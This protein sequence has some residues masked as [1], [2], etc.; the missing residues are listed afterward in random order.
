MMVPHVSNFG[1]HQL[2][3]IKQL[4]EGFDGRLLPNLLDLFLDLPLD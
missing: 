1:G 3:W 2:L 4:A